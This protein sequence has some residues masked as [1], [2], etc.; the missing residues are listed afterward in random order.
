M[1]DE[2]AVAKRGWLQTVR[3]RPYTLAALVFFAVL[4]A[5]FCLRKRSDWDE[6]YIAA[7]ERLTR[8]DDVLQG[9]F[10]YPPINAWLPLPFVSLPKVPRR[11][12]WFAVNAAALVV[13][14]RI[15]WDLSGG[16]RLQGEPHVS[17]REHLICILGLL[18]GGCYV[19]DALTNQQTDIL[20]A[21]LVLAGCRLLC[22][23][24]DM[25]AGVTFG[26]AAAIKC[27]PLLWAPYLLWRRRWRAALL[28]PLVAVGMNLVPDWTHPNGR[29]GSRLVDWGRRLLAPMAERERD[30][31]I[32]ACGLSSNHS[33]AGVCYR[34]LAWQ[35]TWQNRQFTAAPRPGRPSPTQ[36]KMVA[37][38]VMLVF[39]SIFLT[40][41][42]FGARRARAALTDRQP[43]PIA[44]E[45]GL[46]L[47]LM[48]VLSPQTSKPHFCTLLFP[49][50]CLARAALT[51]RS[52]LQGAFLLAAMVSG[53]ASNKDLVGGYFYDWAVWYG[54]IS[55]SAIWLFAGCCLA[56]ARYP[57]PTAASLALPAIRKAA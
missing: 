16:G 26:L 46:V 5:P 53:L 29:P 47:I 14:V 13:L 48:L 4:I 23:R 37:Y 45:Y 31:G 32:W 9:G 21:A 27:T 36:L 34:L 30:I 19:L 49:G 6:V 22:T 11:L 7:A 8:G 51:W 2:S 44:F 41:S 57:Q 35:P 17:G 56:L 33:T 54:N 38:S 20:L 28:V 52:R 3:S 12:L 42:I 40:C 1:T 43:S 10:V 18:C 50:F 39:V 15:A 55:A 25:A 24:R